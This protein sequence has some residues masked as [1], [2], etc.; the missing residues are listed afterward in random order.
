MHWTGRKS[1]SQK[2]VTVTVTVTETGRQLPLPLP[3]LPLPHHPHWQQATFDI[4]LGHRALLGSCI[5]HIS[6]LRPL[7]AQ[8]Q[9]LRPRPHSVP[10]PRP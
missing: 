6:H 3:L 10:F 4:A 5:D 2:A 7:S 1:E 9:V 8:C